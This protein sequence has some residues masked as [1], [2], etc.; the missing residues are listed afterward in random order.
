MAVVDAYYI[1]SK[2]L[3]TN[4]EYFCTLNYNYKSIYSVVITTQM[5]PFHPIWHVS[6]NFKVYVIRKKNVNQLSFGGQIERSGVVIAMEDAAEDL[7]ADE[8]QR[9]GGALPAG[10]IDG[11]LLFGNIFSVAG[12]RGGGGGH[13]VVERVRDGEGR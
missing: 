10:Q 3:P 1:I 2:H 13:E 6:I 7:C 8:T 4:F 11:S 12:G 5:L 9:R